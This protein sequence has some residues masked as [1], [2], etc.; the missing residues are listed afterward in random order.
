MCK[1]N[2]YFPFSDDVITVAKALVSD[3]LR[4]MDGDYTPYYFCIY[5]DA[6]LKGYSATEKDFKHDP[7]CPVLVAQD[8]LTR[9][10]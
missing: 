5:C 4:Y 9:C 7:D 10:Q 1:F 2:K 3:P 6:E 8:L